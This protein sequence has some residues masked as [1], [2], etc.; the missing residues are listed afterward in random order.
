MFSRLIIVVI[1]YEAENEIR[2]CRPVVFQFRH[3]IGVQFIQSTDLFQLIPEE[4]GVILFSR[5][6]QVM[7][8]SDDV[9]VDIQ[10][11]GVKANEVDTGRNGRRA[12]HETI[13]LLIAHGEHHGHGIP[14]CVLDGRI[15]HVIDLCLVLC[16]DLSAA[17]GD[18]PF[19]IILGKPLLGA[20]EE[21]FQE[22]LHPVPVINSVLIHFRR[23]ELHRH[24][25]EI[26]IE[27][28]IGID[29]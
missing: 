23:D 7:P 20:A 19:L 25:M 12:F 1:V 8:V 29:G 2:Q 6:A 24:G 17:H 18:R 4:L 5:I 3:C 13:G 22:V 21:I 15:C 9:Q 26:V 10:H 14:H 27:V 28:E 11:A 16:P